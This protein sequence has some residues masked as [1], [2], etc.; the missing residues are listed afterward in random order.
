MTVATTLPTPEQTRT[1]W[2]R[3][4]LLM[5]G[6]SL[7]P[8]AVGAWLYFVGWRPAQ[9]SNHGTLITP[10]VAVAIDT[11]KQRWSLVLLGDGDCDA[12]CA[13]RLDE[14]RRVRVSLAK[15]MHRTQ[16][17]RAV[18]PAPLADLPTGTVI[19][20]DPDGRAMMRYTPD[21]EAK[22]MRA[23]LERLLKYSWTG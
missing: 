17:L 7:L 20:V 18:A 11:V 19:I 22:G 23:D 16:Y 5:V 12:P 13:A 1:A 10:P 2:R 6:L 15:E 4:L 21:A 14:L 8:I 3:A 9:T